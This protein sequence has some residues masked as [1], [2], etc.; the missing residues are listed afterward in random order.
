ME[1]E[2]K[3][4]KKAFKPTKVPKI[5]KTKSAAETSDTD[6]IATGKAPKNWLEIW[7]GIEL[8]RG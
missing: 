8:M 1:E 6:I 2:K 4:V 5:A 3:V 7:D